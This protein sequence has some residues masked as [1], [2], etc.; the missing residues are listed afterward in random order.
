MDK[1]RGELIS[2]LKSIVVANAL[3][4]TKWKYMR[5]DGGVRYVLEVVFCIR[6]E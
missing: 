4:V 2:I 3:S 6:I 1:R 5:A